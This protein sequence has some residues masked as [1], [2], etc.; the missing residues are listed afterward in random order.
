V[1]RGAAAAP[2]PIDRRA[3]L[4]ATL[5]AA[6][7]VAAGC[8]T[9]PGPRSGEEGET[10]SG[11]LAVRVEASGQASTRSLSAAFDLRGTPDAGTLGLSTPLGTLL[12]QARWSPAEV[13]LATPQGTRRFDS[14]EA[15]TRE[16]LGESVPIEAWFDWLRG[17][18][19]PGAPSEPAPSTGGPPS[20]AGFAQLGWAVDLTGFGEG[21]VSATR[22]APAPA[23]T[24]RIRL[25]RS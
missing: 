16:V 1:T 8:A 20:A 17:R 15:L 2:H 3:G 6:A 21:A 22:A 13:V 7:L 9:V 5:A 11:R 4:V 10:L 19:W 25:D 14:L 12:A 24:V 18:P 23:V